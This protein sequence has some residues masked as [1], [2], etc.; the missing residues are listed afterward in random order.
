MPQAEIKVIYVQTAPPRN[1]DAGACVEA[2]YSVAGDMLHMVDAD[3]RKTGK[4][5][6]LVPGESERRVAGRLALEA[7]SAESG[8]L[9]K[10]FNRPLH[11]ARGGVA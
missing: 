2:F 4:S 1:G 5:A 9:V 3:G 11:Y 8:E 10:G 7:W 6:R